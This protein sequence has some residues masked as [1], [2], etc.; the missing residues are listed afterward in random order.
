MSR[1]DYATPLCLIEAVE[2]RFGPI[3]HDL[4]ATSG[5]TK[6]ATWYGPDRELGERDSLA[7]AWAARHPR[8]NLWLNPPFARV[9]SWMAKCHHE[10]KRR[11]GLILS[12]T[13]ASVGSR[14]FI[15]H[16]HGNALVMP[17]CPRVTFV[18]EPAP[19]NRDLMLCAWGEGLVG[20]VPWVWR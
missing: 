19:F 6:A 4:A 13:L 14:W 9:A 18:G 2:R 17:L 5:N 15:D 1:Q 12:L 7:I 8:G 11:Q 3:V 10:S 20:F 16:V